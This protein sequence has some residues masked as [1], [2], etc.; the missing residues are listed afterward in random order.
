M[1][2][3]MP[4]PIEK[5]AA[6]ES[7]LSYG[8]IRPKSLWG[9]LAEL[10]RSL[11]LRA[12]FWDTGQSVVIAICIS[13]CF[14]LMLYFMRTRYIYASL[15]VLSPMLFLL[16]TLTT[17]IIE[18]AGGLHELKMTCKYTPQQVAAFRM[19]CFS[20]LGVVSCVLMT[21]SIPHKPMEFLRLLSLSLSALFLYALLITGILQRLRGRNMFVAAAWAVTG[22]LPPLIWGQAWDTFL[23]RLPMFITAGIAILSAVL[24]LMELKKFI[25]TTKMEDLCYV[26]G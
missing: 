18:R 8:L 20:G 12:I 23:S 6:I 25:L 1:N 16:S 13:I 19:L 9:Q 14:G 7:I 22:L 24:Y 11:G 3:Q 4:D 5:N 15:F 17:E 2:I 10:Y 21:A 26:N